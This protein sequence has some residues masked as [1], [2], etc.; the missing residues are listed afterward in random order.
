MVERMASEAGHEGTAAE[1]REMGMGTCM[2]DWGQMSVSRRGSKERCGWLV[3][4]ANRKKKK[5][6]SSTVR[7]I[8]VRPVQSEKGTTSKVVSPQVQEDASREHL[9]IE[10]RS[11]LFGLP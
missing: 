8:S 10:G 4:E 9:Y 1:Q 2:E 5:N 3:S 11:N 6:I 7:G